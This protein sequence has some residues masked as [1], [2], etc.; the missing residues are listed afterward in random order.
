MKQSNRHLIT[1]FCLLLFMTA[2]TGCGRKG[3]PVAPGAPELI[4]VA[5]VSYELS[6]DLVRISWDPAKGVGA[7]IVTGY[8]VHRS[9]V[10]IA[11]DSCEGCPVLFQRVAELDK[12][13]HSYGEMLEKG[14]RYIY[15]V[16]SVST[17]GTISPDSE[18]IKFSY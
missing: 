2:F 11:E 5:G 8:V 14:N 10:P 7:S 18:Y 9:V 6:D 13:V 17:Y 1:A 12:T 4:P 3:P 15:K 16:V